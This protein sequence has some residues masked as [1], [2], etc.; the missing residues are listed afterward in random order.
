MLSQ[1]DQADSIDS[2]ESKT[3]IQD[4]TS[5]FS[6]KDWLNNFHLLVTIILAIVTSV[7][8]WKFQAIQDEFK[9]NLDFMHEIKPA[10]SELSE[11]KSSAR[12]KMTLV[13]LY[14]LA[15]NDKNKYILVNLASASDNLELM[16]TIYNLLEGEYP[17]GV[18]ENALK[19]NSILAAARAR[20]AKKLEE[21]ANPGIPPSQTND[22]PVRNIGAEGGKRKREL[23]QARAN[24]LSQ[25]T[26]NGT[27][28]WIY[29]GREPTD[30]VENVSDAIPFDE[31]RRILKAPNY[32]GILTKPQEITIRQDVNLRADRP[33]SYYKVNQLPGLVGVLRKDS[34]VV[35]QAIYRV[36]SANKRIGIW[37]KVVV[38]K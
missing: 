20:L 26:P 23:V 21:S 18:P 8:S 1:L 12:Y 7:M 4:K 37:A 27:S 25:L 17:Q 36:Y 31:V 30:L 3:S 2:S 13:S 14:T 16:E 22:N 33:F 38:T 19:T 32:R 29:F 24:L 6:L 5:K 9:R 28:G 15:E 34:K 10:I 35:V 11:S